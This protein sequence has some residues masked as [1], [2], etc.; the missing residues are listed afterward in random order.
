M[1]RRMIEYDE[2]LPTSPWWEPFCAKMT[3]WYSS[4]S[5]VGRDVD[6]LIDTNQINHV[7]KAL[8]TP[9]S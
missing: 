8:A 2:S 7:S 1:R 5:F 3:R 6:I 4:D 9:M